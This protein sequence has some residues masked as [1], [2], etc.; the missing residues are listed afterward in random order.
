MI[1]FLKR[2]IIKTS[3]LE[4][5]SLTRSAQGCR[6]NIFNK[7]LK[8]QLPSTLWEKAT[9]CESPRYSRHVY[10]YCLHHRYC[11]ESQPLLVTVPINTK[12]LTVAAVDEI[13]SFRT[14]SLCF[15]SRITHF[16][17]SW[18]QNQSTR[19]VSTVYT[20]L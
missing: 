9:T 19:N 16:V 8:R 17:G 6:A 3:L 12:Q 18:R 7:K 14:L 15:E 10:Q 5:P 2:S 4:N 20:K 13:W 11:T 1:I